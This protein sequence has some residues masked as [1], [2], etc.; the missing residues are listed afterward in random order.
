MRR[1][2]VRWDWPTVTLWVP[3]V[4][5]AALSPAGIGLEEPWAGSDLGAAVT[6]LAL[7]APLAVRRTRPA[8]TAALVAAAVPLQD[9]LGGSLS[10]ATFL[11]VLVA[12]YALGRYATV[13]RAALGVG[14]MLVG[15]VVAMRHSI[16]EDAVEL[17]FPL[18]YVTATAALG[19]VVRRLSPQAADLRRLN[20]ALGR[21]RDAT[22]RLAV[23]TERIRLARDLHDV[24][25]HTLTVAVVQAEA[26]E[27]AI[28]SDPDRARVAAQQVQ[29]AGRR[30]LADLR[31]MVRVLR[32]AEA[33]TADPGLADVG[34]LATVMAGAGLDVAV[35][36]EGKLGVV[37]P[38]VGQQL[39]RVVQ[40]AL[41]NVVKHSAAT[42]AV[43]AV[44]VAPAE[45]AVT[46]AD[47]GPP[48]GTG[49]AGAVPSGGHGIKGMRERLA[50]YDGTLAAGPDGSG[51]R[52]HARVPLARERT[53]G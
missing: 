22:T 47:P 17:V 39:F 29:D 36:S 24:V 12:A 30:G 11:T 28:E 1:P 19:S 25:A 45:V 23:A 51:F 49:P 13:D 5:V 18:F 26:C 52:V 4:A 14:V 15:I 40:E 7:A 44:D 53:L 10:F 37:P 48:L 27:E 9:A 35:R 21:E 46:V 42:S 41:T 16:P 2:Q 34:T 31:S 8:V 3:V 32:D 38:E 50:P 20:E 43:V 6:A 33:S